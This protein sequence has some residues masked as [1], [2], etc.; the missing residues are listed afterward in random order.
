MKIVKKSF[1]IPM[2]L[3][4]MGVFL[5][6]C[7]SANNSTG[8]ETAQ[9]QKEWYVSTK[10]SVNNAYIGTNP[11]VFGRLSSSHDGVDKNDIPT[12]GS[13]VGR[14]AAVV[15]I[16]NNAKEQAGEYHSNYRDTQ[17]ENETWEMTVFSSV[18]N[19]EVTLTWDGLYMLTRKES[20]YDKKKLLNSPILEELY[21]VDT[22][23]GEIINAVDDGKLNTY[24]FKMGETGSRTFIWV[25]G[26]SDSYAQSNSVKTYIQTKKNVANTKMTKMVEI[27]V[28]SGPENFPLPPM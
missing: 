2:I 14:K 21:L 26:K 12:Y 3:M 22:E 25:F 8:E 11:A 27:T 17:D 13:V 5:A 6:S 10:V 7:Q 24:T 1:M 16:Q 4:T 18:R 28:N 23:T 15:F 20:G 9:A 19:A